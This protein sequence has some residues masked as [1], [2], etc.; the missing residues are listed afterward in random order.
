[1]GVNIDKSQ[2]GKFPVL[3]LEGVSHSS[4]MDS[5][6]LPSAVVSDDIKPEAD[7]KTAHNMVGKAM[8]S[9]IASTEGDHE[10][11]KLDSELVQFTDDFMKPLVEAMT[12]EGGIAMKEPSST[13]TALNAFKALHGRSKPKGSW[14][15]SS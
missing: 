6:M 12:L 7:E 15:A 13:A 3:A 10:A 4:F 11:G 2:V 1:M 9:F 5:T 8:V 14:A